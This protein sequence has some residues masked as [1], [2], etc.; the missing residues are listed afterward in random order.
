MGPDPATLPVACVRY[1]NDACQDQHYEPAPEFVPVLKT[2]WAEAM[3]IV[4]KVAEGNLAWH[5]NADLVGRARALLA[6]MGEKEGG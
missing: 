1:W 5:D 2:R 6:R 4:E 3:R